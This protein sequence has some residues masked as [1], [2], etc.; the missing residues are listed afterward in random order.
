[1]YVC[2]LNCFYDHVF[3]LLSLVLISLFYYYC[4]GDILEILGLLFLSCGF[5]LL[6][7]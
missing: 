6:L 5:P 2:V 3:R 1:M 7:D 4:Y